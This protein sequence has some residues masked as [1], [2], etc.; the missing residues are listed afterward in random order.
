MTLPTS[1]PS[2]AAS[3]SGRRITRQFRVPDFANRA[4]ILSSLSPEV[5]AAA[6]HTPA[7][8]ARSTLLDSIQKADVQIGAASLLSSAS[9]LTSFAARDPRT[10]V[11]AAIRQD[12]GAAVREQL[13]PGTCG[14]MGIQSYNHTH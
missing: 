12:G 3:A 11:L 14:Q 7:V 4:R 13:E 8:I 5:A 10:A 9:A 6:S 1:D 2:T